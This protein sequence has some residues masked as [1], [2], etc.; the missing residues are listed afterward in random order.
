[1]FFKDNFK[2]LKIRL[3]AGKAKNATLKNI[4]YGDA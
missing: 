3:L 1:M 2:L 4:T